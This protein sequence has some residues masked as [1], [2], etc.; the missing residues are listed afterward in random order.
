MS[1]IR[2]RSLSSQRGISLVGLV[3]VAILV[4]FV[5]LMGVR[6]FPLVN[7]YLT[8]RRAVATIMRANPAGPNEV[9]TAFEKATEVEYSI[10]TISA[11]DL[12]ITQNGDKLTTRFA[13]NA[14]IPIIDPVF[15]VIKFQ[16]SASSGGGV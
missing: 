11:K 5:M 15:L 9:R 2:L 12:D 4:G 7:E 6:V 16:G 14:E 3:V 1:P 10:H 8:I 13:Y